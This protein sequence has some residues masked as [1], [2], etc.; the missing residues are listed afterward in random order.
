[1]LFFTQWFSAFVALF[2]TLA[3]FSSLAE[4]KPIKTGPRDERCA[5][6]TKAWDD[7]SRWSEL[8]EEQTDE[9]G[10]LEPSADVPEDWHEE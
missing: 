4:E 6:L 8:C 5:T 10:Y 1:M 2:I 3:A 9:D 7:S